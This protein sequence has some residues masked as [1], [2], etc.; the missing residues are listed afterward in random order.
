MVVGQE[1]ILEYGFSGVHKFSIGFDIED[2]ID[3]YTFF[4]GLDV[5]GVNGQ[6]C[7]FE[8]KNIETFSGL[9]SGQCD[10]RIHL[11]I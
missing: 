8:L 4:V 9:F 11:L 7:S 2:G 6:F 10:C 5:V 1:D 3:E